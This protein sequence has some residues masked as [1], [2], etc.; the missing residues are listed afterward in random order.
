MSLA[1][2]DTLMAQDGWAG[3]G[4]AGVGSGAPGAVAD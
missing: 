4:A 2:C 1:D 3:S